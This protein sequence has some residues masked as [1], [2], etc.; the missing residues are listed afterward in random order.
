MRAQICDA[1]DTASL[2]RLREALRC[3]GA[4][5]DGDLPCPGVVFLF[6]RFA[7]EKVVVSADEWTVDIDGPAAV[8]EKI[9]ASMRK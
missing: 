8:V 2:S 4:A 5:P 6:F 9:I 3:L 1:S 7:N